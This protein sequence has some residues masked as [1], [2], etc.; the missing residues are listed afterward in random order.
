MTKMVFFSS[1]PADETYPLADDIPTASV[2]GDG[3]DESDPEDSDTPWV[4]TLKIR[5][6]HLPSGEL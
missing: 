2:E 3:G 6:A 5:R 1:I 4:C